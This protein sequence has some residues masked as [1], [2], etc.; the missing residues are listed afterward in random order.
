[1]AEI[2]TQV[3]AP[4][5]IQSG[6]I[7]Q[8]SGDSNTARRLQ[9]DAQPNVPL[10]SNA[11]PLESPTPTPTP[12]PGPSV[13][14]ETSTVTPPPVAGAEIS[15]KVVQESLDRNKKESDATAASRAL[16]GE[17]YGL[18]AGAAP[19]PDKIDEQKAYE[20]ARSF[21][22]SSGDLQSKGIIPAIELAYI[23]DD[24]GLSSK[25][26]APENN[27]TKFA[28]ADGG[29]GTD[30][31]TISAKDLA[32][33]VA[34]KSNKYDGVDKAIAE[35]LIKSRFFTD[36]NLTTAYSREQLLQMVK[37]SKKEYNT[38]HRN[39]SETP[40]TA[41]ETTPIAAATN[42]VTPETRAQAKQYENEIKGL[43]Q[44]NTFTRE[45][46]D[47]LNKGLVQKAQE[48]SAATDIPEE[49][50]KMTLEQLAK[51]NDALK[52][53]DQALKE[54]KDQPLTADQILTAPKTDAQTQT[55]ELSQTNP[56]QME[57]A[58]RSRKNELAALYPGGKITKGETEKHRVS[59]KTNLE[60]IETSTTHTPEQKAQAKSIL[61]PYLE[62]LSIAEAALKQSNGEPVDLKTLTGAS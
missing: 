54:N 24:K 53:V 23:Q 58:A 62:A 28:A 10:Q 8:F 26:A 13:P 43:S 7:Y 11:Q 35:S 51:H 61:A 4:T 22:S 48:V 45:A 27:F 34:D 15:G 12:T 49:Q 31:T 38:K 18:A 42:S 57:A 60:K 44:G 47:A 9:A 29:Q 3:A 59:A 55:P 56:E 1:M 20:R 2:D 32:A 6:N 52:I 50:K 41:P 19:S 39:I 25:G 40:A 14:N 46:V 17:A 30:A 21:L 37:D 33:V 36:Q 16:T 5:D